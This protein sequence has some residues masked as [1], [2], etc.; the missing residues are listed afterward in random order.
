M[1]YREVAEFLSVAMEHSQQ[2]KDLEWSL[3]PILRWMGLLGIPLKFKKYTGSNTNNFK[4]KN[5][6]W[7]SAWLGLLMLIA[8]IV[9]FVTLITLNVLWFYSTK[10]EETVIR[11]R[12][13]STY[14]W[15]YFIYM[16]SDLFNTL[17]SHLALMFLVLPK[18]NKLAAILYYMER[19]RFFDTQIYNRF[20]RVC[21]WG[22]GIIIMVLYIARYLIVR[23]RYKIIISF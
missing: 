18:W 3:S 9:R 21:L 14:S 17:G 2:N 8:S 1:S 7:L 4:F 13:G 20:R 6:S 16:F 11:K 23:S 10:S 12:P 22:L 15:S 5:H 19:R